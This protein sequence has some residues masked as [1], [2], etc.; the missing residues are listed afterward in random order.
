M[1]INLEYQ[2]SDKLGM[3]ITALDFSV[4]MWI[5]QYDNIED[6]MRWHKEVTA[7]S[8][9]DDEVGHM[10][11]KVRNVVFPEIA[12]YGYYGS[13]GVYNP[14]R[15]IQGGVAFDMYQEFRTKHA[16]FLHPEGGWTREFDKPLWCKDD[17][18]D[19]PAASLY[20][21]GDTTVATLTICK[22]QK[23]ILVKSLKAYSLLLSTKLTDMLRIFTDNKEA[24][25]LM[26]EVEKFYAAIPYDQHMFS[27]EDA[28]MFWELAEK[29]EGQEE[30]KR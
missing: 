25:D 27:L 26:E 7:E 15:P 29:I 3:I 28:K 12:D 24:L 2:D 4:R 1:R 13:H 17:P 14:K 6:I 11:L 30:E 21:D 16:Y 9:I 10:L 5:G 8:G 18:Y 23:D 22:E 20:R 19:R